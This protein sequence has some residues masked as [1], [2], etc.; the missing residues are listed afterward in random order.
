[1]SDDDSD[2]LEEM[3]DTQLGM[4]E[5][6]FGYDFGRMTTAEVVEFVHWNVTALT[7]ELHEALAETS[8]K[9]W[10]DSEFL[11]REAYTGELVDAWHFLMNLML[12]VG[13]TP[14]ELR[15][16]YRIKQRINVAR[17]SEG[18]DGVSTKCPVCGRALDD[19]TV[20]CEPGIC[21]GATA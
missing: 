20:D 5:A 15:E 3:M 11:N 10:A 8:W 16:K 17:Q 7:D 21:R 2:M 6:V 14:H 18:Y 12:A 4:Q 1:M 19:P 9:P 13:M